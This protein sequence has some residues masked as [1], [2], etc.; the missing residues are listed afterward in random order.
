MQ[1][2]LGAAVDFYGGKAVFDHN[3]LVESCAINT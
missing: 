1:E 3:K 2:K